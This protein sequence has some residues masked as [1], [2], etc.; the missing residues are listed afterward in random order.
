MADY[1]PYFESVSLLS[2]EQDALTF[3]AVEGKGFNF[4]AYKKGVIDV[5]ASRY[6]RVPLWL[7]VTGSPF[8]QRY[9]QSLRCD[10]P[11]P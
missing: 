3:Y 5:I 4:A 11:A 1:A 6:Y 10:K 9:Y 2:F 8:C 7:P